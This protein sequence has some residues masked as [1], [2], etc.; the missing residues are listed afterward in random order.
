MKISVVFALI[1]AMVF[2]AVTAFA[3]DKGD[4]FTYGDMANT[5]SSGVA[6]QGNA[7]TIT[8][9]SAI[10]NTGGSGI[11]G[12]A[13][14]TANGG[15]GGAG[16][17]GGSV[18]INKDAIK[19][20]NESNI[21][22]GNSALGGKS[23]SPE[24]KAEVNNVNVGINAQKQ[25]QGQM[26]GQQQKQGQIQGQQMNNKQVIAPRQEITFEAPKAGVGVGTVLPGQGVPELNFGA[27]SMKDVTLNMP[28]FAI[29]GYLP[30]RGETISEVLSVTANVKF[31]NLFKVILEDAKALADKGYKSGEVKILVFMADAQKSWTTGGNLGAGGAG[32]IGTGGASLGGSIVPQWGGTKADPL[33]TVIYVKVIP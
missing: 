2:V 20:T 8:N 29:Y 7:N 10:T 12:T 26:Q 30:Y 16:G 19:N 33:G 32:A 4:Q 13:T 6:V 28:K 1:L 23:F 24:A 25:Q 14:V 5:G 17:A 11:G 18:T 15:A 21:N 9:T 27:G 3:G 22:I 31:K